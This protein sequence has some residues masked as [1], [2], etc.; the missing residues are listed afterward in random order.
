MSSEFNNAEKQKSGIASSKSGQG[1]EKSETAISKSGH[2]NKKAR[3]KLQN[4]DRVTKE[5][6]NDF[7]IGTGSQKSMR[8]TS[9]SG[10][11]KEAGH[12]LRNRDI[13]IQ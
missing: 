8:V 7:N 1:D 11:N 5:W 10:E 6:D 13:K 3:Q 4:R 2:G 9:I 12:R